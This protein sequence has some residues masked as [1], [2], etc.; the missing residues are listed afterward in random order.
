VT[1]RSEAV[2]AF[3][4][5]N[6]TATLEHSRELLNIVPGCTNSTILLM[7]VRLRST[8]SSSTKLRA[9]RALS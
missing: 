4:E 5:G 9:D 8:E 7:Q 2:R 6:W 3:L 1:F